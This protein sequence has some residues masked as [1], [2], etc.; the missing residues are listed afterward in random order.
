MLTSLDLRKPKLQ[1]VRLS[2]LML[3]KTRRA[4]GR[5]VKASRRRPKKTLLFQS[6]LRHLLYL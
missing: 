6:R 3:A 1:L 5:L 4:P 2:L